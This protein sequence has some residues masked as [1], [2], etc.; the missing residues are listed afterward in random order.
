[1]MAKKRKADMNSGVFVAGV[2][3]LV[4]VAGGAQAAEP[5]ER[6]H[7]Q[8]HEITF[9]PHAFLDEDE[10]ALLRLVMRDAGALALFLP[11]GNHFAAL[12]AA[13]DEGV[14][15]DGAIVGSATALSGLPDLRVTA[16]EAL[17][18]CDRARD[19]GPA[20]VIV[21]TVAPLP[22]AAP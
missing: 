2:A 12:A 8:G 21:L 6:A 16:D 18:A 3:A 10:R 20:C 13:P 22:G 15:Q 14:M 11:E 1:M 4:V 9:H 5:V 7:F 17:R 19:G